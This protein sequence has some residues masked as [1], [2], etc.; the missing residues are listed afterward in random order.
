VDWA[1]LDVAL[2]GN[3][4][5][6]SEPSRLRKYLAHDVEDCCDNA[7]TANLYAATKVSA[8]LYRREANRPELSTGWA[9]GPREV[10][11]AAMGVFF[12][13]DPRGEGDAVLPML[14]TFTDP[15][16]FGERLRWWLPRADARAD[17]GRKARAAIA[18]RTFVNHARQLLRL[19]ESKE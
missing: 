19:L 10:E 16:D 8:N 12:L 18:D 5:G 9:M 6:L 3:W 14:P 2:A 1:G 11:L 15:G 7:Q 17:A 4:Q 13:R